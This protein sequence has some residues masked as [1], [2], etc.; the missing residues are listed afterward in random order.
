LIGCSAVVPE[1][2]GAS[3]PRYEVVKTAGTKIRYPR[4]GKPQERLTPDVV[5]HVVALATEATTTRSEVLWASVPENHYGCEVS[6]LKIY[7]RPSTRTARYRQGNWAELV[8]DDGVWSVRGT[9]DYLELSRPDG[10]F[11]KSRSL[12]VLSEG[13]PPPDVIVEVVDRAWRERTS[14]GYSPTLP[15]GVSNSLER[16]TVTFYDNKHF[17]YVNTSYDCANNPCELVEA[18]D[19]TWGR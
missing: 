6:Y 16:V 17:G 9:G 8:K 15:L 13:H 14:S 12:S 18:P 19:I 7:F 5:R 3:A 10:R 2:R 4:C 1:S 11:R